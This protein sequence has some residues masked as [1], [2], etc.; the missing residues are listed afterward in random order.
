MWIEGISVYTMMTL[1]HLHDL[2]R[3]AP[4]SLF[5]TY[6]RILLDSMTY[7]RW[8]VGTKHFP[9]SKTLPRIQK[10]LPESKTLPRIQTHFQE[11]KH[12]S[13]NPKYFCLILGRVFEFWYVFWSLGNVLDSGTYFW[14]LA[15]VLDSGKRFV[16]IS[17]G[18]YESLG[19]LFIK[20]RKSSFCTLKSFRSGC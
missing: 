10:H 6:V 9:E 13:K 1:T 16:P 3:S 7:V 5:L 17:H 15:R 8:L 4:I 2:C 11:T 12:T 19:L 18:S 14:I 20:L